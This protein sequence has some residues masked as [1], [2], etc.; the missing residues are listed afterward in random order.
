MQDGTR[1]IQWIGL[2]VSSRTFTA[3]L[4]N[5]FT[6]Q[7]IRP[8]QEKFELNRRGVRQL[9]SW[10]HDIGGGEPFGIAMET[11]GPYSEK[12]AKLISDERKDLHVSLCNAGSISHYMRSFTEAKSD[13]ADASYIARYAAERRPAPRIPAM[14]EAEML[15][16]ATRDR[17]RLVEQRVRML[18]ANA[19]ISSKFV[20]QVND[21][22]IKAIDKAIAELDAKIRAIA[23]ANAEIERE[24]SIMVTCPGVAFISAA[25][26]YAELGSLAQYTRKQLSAL[27]GVCPVR[28]ESGTSVRRSR[29]SRRGSKS[30]KRILF[31]DAQFA[32]RKIPAIK[33]LHE[34][35]MTRVDSS[36]LTARCACMRKLL[37]TLRGM[38]VSQRAF[39]PDYK[40][41]SY[42]KNELTA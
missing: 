1:L 11:T 32:M 21:G 25:T 30:L 8:R 38:V 19:T 42:K 9:L 2:D 17:E 22:V 14:P 4:A 33:A 27:S 35:L 12:L 26:I 5:A 36:K 40:P 28:I 7:T 34:K 13:K 3:A 37:L 15:R 31:L 24:I 29:I 39:D 16:A 18:E 20:L 23:M 6:N 41:E 10:A